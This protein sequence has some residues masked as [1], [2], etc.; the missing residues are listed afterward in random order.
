MT[1]TRVV[2]FSTEQTSRSVESHSFEYGS[3]LLLLEH[4]IL[5]LLELVTFVLFLVFHLIWMCLFKFIYVAAL[6]INLLSSIPSGLVGGFVVFSI[7]DS[8]VASVAAI[9]TFKTAVSIWFTNKNICNN[10]DL[11]KPQWFKL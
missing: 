7:Y 11:F 3:Q 6:L 8:R 10:L 2:T 9:F 4:I 5:L 1:W